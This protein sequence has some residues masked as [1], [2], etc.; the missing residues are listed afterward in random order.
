VHQLF[1]RRGELPFGEVDSVVTVSNTGGRAQEAAFILTLLGFAD[2]RSLAG[3][4]DGWERRG[5]PLA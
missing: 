4:L 1:V 3:G 2:V 5:F